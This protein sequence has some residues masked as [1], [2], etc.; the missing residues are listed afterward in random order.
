M[1]IYKTEADAK[2]K[3]NE[4]LIPLYKK[5]KKEKVIDYCFEC[6]HKLGHHYRDIP[7]GKPYGFRKEKKSVLYKLHELYVK[8]LT[9]FILNP[10]Q[11]EGKKIHINKFEKL[12]YE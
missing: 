6:G 4:V 3:K 10:V 8:N 7:V 5:Y 11:I 1:K 9:E 12:K 2:L